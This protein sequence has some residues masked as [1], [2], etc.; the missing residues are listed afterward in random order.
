MYNIANKI[1][2]NLPN[3]ED[4]QQKQEPSN[5]LLSRN[6]QKPS[7]M[8]KKDDDPRTRVA[9]YAMEIRKGRMELKNGKL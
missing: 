2:N 4:Q 8:G 3:I 5:G 7:N 6:M 9:R 1:Y